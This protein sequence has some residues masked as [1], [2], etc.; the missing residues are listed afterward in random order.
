MTK[1]TKLISFSPST[2]SKYIDCNASSWYSFHED[3]K[4]ELFVDKFYADIGNAIHESLLEL[5][6]YA[7]KK[8]Y[9]GDDID[10]VFFI[11]FFYTQLDLQLETFS[12]SMKN[13]DV[14]ERIVSIRSGIEQCVKLILTDIKF[15]AVDPTSKEILVWEEQWLDHNDKKEGVYLDDSIRSKTRADVIG[16]YND[17]NDNKPYVLVRDYKTGKSITDP[18]TD[19]GL[20]M[21]GIWSLIELNNPLANWF[22]INR[23]LDINDSYVILEAV[24]LGAKKSSDFSIRSILYYKDLPAIVGS[25]SNVINKIEFVKQ[26]V[27]QEIDAPASPGGLCKDYCPYLHRCNF[28][29]QHVALRFG[30]ESLENRI[31]SNQ[32]AFTDYVSN[33]NLLLEQLTF[34]SMQQCPNCQSELHEVP[35]PKKNI[36]IKKLLQCSQ[37]PNCKF[38][39]P[40][41]LKKKKN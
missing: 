34:I 33:R 5:Q 14:E 1:K 2:I 20:L 11:N 24:N 35:S 30:I 31:H 17:K 16:I 39:I 29:K 26:S 22:V 7:K 8:F 27:D 23:D 28:G 10:Y 6:K 40:T 32:K 4:G 9:I 12:L 41:L 38:Q 3:E 13:T 37:F 25:F 18:R 19:P 15:W 21:R 36:Y